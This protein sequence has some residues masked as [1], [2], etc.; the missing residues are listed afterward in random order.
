MAGIAEEGDLAAGVDPGLEGLAVHELPV[1]S[2][3][4]EREDLLEP[5]R[6]Q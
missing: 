6:I 3:G 1:E 4:N 2:G 5:K